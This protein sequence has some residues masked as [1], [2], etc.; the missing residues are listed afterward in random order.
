M[1]WSFMACVYFRHP[2]RTDLKY[3][4]PPVPKHLYK[5][6]ILSGYA[7]SHDHTEDPSSLSVHERAI[8]LTSEADYAKALEEAELIFDQ[9]YSPSLPPKDESSPYYAVYAHSEARD[10]HARAAGLKSVPPTLHNRLNSPSRMPVNRIK[11]VHKDINFVPLNSGACKLAQAL[12]YYEQCGGPK[13][14]YLIA[15]NIVA[16]DGSKKSTEG[17]RWSIVLRS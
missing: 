1:S 17:A 3:E 4:L 5:N 9:K 2:F 6:A 15:D 14:F 11:M 10:I 16:M 13:P 7:I 8:K 12:S